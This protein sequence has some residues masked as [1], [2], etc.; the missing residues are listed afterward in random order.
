MNKTTVSFFLCEDMRWEQDGGPMF[1]GVL[2][3]KI[4]SDDYPIIIPKV[5]V[6]TMFRALSGVSEIDAKLLVSKFKQGNNEPESSNSYFTSH[7]RTDECDGEEW[8]IISSLSVDELELQEGD[9][10]VCGL[11]YNGESAT[12]SLTAAQSLNELQN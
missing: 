2:A 4:H 7:K 12:L 3:P 11:D 10:M 8:L 5:H 1:I 6:V 9:K